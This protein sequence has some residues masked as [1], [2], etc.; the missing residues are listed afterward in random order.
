MGVRVSKR[1]WQAIR[2]MLVGGERWTKYSAV[3]ATRST[4]PADDRGGWFRQLNNVYRDTDAE[5]LQRNAPF[6]EV[7][8]W[9]SPGPSRR[10]REIIIGP[11]CG[12]SHDIHRPAD[13]AVPSGMVAWKKANMGIPVER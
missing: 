1:P 12:L 6:M 11:P 4:E 2:G 3:R 9:C 13:I 10:R 5:L 8:V 7:Y